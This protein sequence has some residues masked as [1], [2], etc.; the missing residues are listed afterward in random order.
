VFFRRP[1]RARALSSSAERSAIAPAAVRNAFTLK[2]GA[3]SR[4]SQKAISVSASRASITSLC[5]RRTQNGR[6][7]A[8]DARDANRV[9]PLG[10]VLCRCQ[11]PAVCFV[12]AEAFDSYEVFVDSKKLTS[13]RV[14]LAAA[15][16]F[17]GFD[18]L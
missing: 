7:A 11:T 8:L 5:T 13:C 3:S 15:I 6:G 4:S 1:S 14:S 16:H 17:A 2:T 18:T 12:V 9:P 10:G